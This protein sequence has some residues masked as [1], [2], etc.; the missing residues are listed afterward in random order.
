MR[1]NGIEIN[2]NS[3]VMAKDKLSPKQER[4]CRE[5]VIDFNGTQ[6]AIRAGYSKKTA[7]EQSAQNLAKLSIQ[8][9]IQSLQAKQN[10]E[11]EIT[12]QYLTERIKE[13]GERC[14]QAEQVFDKD[15]NP[16]GEYKFDAF[17][18]LKA[19]ELLGKRTGYFEKDNKQ[20]TAIFAPELTE[21]EMK[22]YREK[23]DNRY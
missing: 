20:K 16:T 8:A 19:W 13:V 18:S 21:E 15:G 11:L 9:F 10:E 5:Y 22:K 1:Q 17:A 23:H 4:F 14:M 2:R 3:K 12:A 6:A 7:N